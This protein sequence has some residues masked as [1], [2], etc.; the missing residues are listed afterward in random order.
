[1]TEKIVNYIHILLVQ[2]IV[3]WAS[4]KTA[5]SN[6]YSSHAIKSIILEDHFYVAFSFIFAYSIHD[7]KILF[8]PLLVIKDPRHLNW[9]H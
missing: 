5:S 7:K 1:M 9:F 4:I 8:L 6:F 3:V 2:N